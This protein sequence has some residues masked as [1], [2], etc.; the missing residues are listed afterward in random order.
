MSPVENPTES[1][2]HLF[3]VVQASR[4]SS[5]PSSVVPAQA[6]TQTPQRSW[7]T[8]THIAL[9]LRTRNPNQSNGLWVPACAA[10][11]LLCVAVAHHGVITGLVP[12]AGP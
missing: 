2:P 7:W 11:T 9:A 4:L 3:F 8:E 10:T 6:G 12:P 1:S 5:P